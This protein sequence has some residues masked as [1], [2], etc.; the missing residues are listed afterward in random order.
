MSYEQNDTT[1]VSSLLMSTTSTNQAS[2]WQSIWLEWNP[3]GRHGAAYVPPCA[4]MYPH[5]P[6]YMT[7]GRDVNT[8]AKGRISRVIEHKSFMGKTHTLSTNGA[9]TM[10]Q[11]SA[12]AW[13]QEFDQVL[14]LISP[15]LVLIRKISIQGFMQ[16]VALTDRNMFQFGGELLL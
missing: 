7:W 4:P 15:E 5:D 2:G 6:P 14:S 9:L 10:D 16:W 12:A 11:S 13:E 3:K 8:W 1:Y